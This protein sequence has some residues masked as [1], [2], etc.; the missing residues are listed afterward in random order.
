MTADTGKT[1]TAEEIRRW[2]VQA[3]AKKLKV[4]PEAIDVNTPFDEF[5]LDSAAAVA[6]SGSLGELL[7]RDLPGTVLYEYPT[8]NE[9]SSHLASRR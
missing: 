7:N 1:M 8:V 6:L 2:L 4:K 5:G 3:I 9:L